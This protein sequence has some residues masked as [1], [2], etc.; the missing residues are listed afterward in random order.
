M[1]RL[2]LAGLSLYIPGCTAVLEHSMHV[3]GVVSFHSDELKALNESSGSIISE[4]LTSGDFKG[5]QVQHSCCSPSCSSD[6]HHC[7]NI[8]QSALAET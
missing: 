6:R 4:M 7:S 8:G 2:F 3:D 5:A 1:C